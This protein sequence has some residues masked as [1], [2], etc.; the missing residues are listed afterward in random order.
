MT[1]VVRWNQY[2]KYCY[3]E[4]THPRQTGI[5]LRKLI[6]AILNTSTPVF[7]KLT[8]TQWVEVIQSELLRSAKAVFE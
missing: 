5:F 6:L 7:W 1:I 2:L 4:H 3:T 8:H